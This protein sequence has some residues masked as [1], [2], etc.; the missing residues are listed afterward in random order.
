M[1]FDPNA[2][3]Q[4]GSGIFGLPHNEA[5]ARVVLL[6]VPWEATT[7]Y[8]GGASKGPRAIREASAQV[9]LYDLDVDRPYMAGIFMLDEAEEILLANEEGKA[10]AATIIEA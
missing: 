9:D 3:A 1:S 2:P 4:P 10:L 8:G 7:S 5:E 6:P